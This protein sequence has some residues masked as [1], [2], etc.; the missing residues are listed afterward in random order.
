[1]SRRV[2][3]SLIAL[4]V[5]VGTV[6]PARA[7]QPDPLQ[8]VPLEPEGPASPGLIAYATPVEPP[9][10]SGA[11]VLAAGVLNVGTAQ[12]TAVGFEVSGPASTTITAVRDTASSSLDG[13]SGPTSWSCD[14]LRCRI[15]PA[16]VLE[17]GGSTT[18]L[19]GIDMPTGVRAEDLSIAPLSGD[20]AGF[21]AKVSA[22]ADDDRPHS[23]I[24]VDSGAPLEVTPGTDL[25]YEVLV[26]NLGD[27]AL[28][29]TKVTVADFVPPDAQT[30]SAT[31][32]GWE[33]ET[34]T[35]RCT[36]SGRFDPMAGPPPVSVTMTAA[37]DTGTDQAPTRVSIETADGRNLNGEANVEMRVSLPTTRGVHAQVRDGD[38][39]IEAGSTASVPVEIAS[40]DHRSSIVET[41][42]LAI[43]TPDGLVVDHQKLAGWD[44]E[45]EEAETICHHDGPIAGDTPL[46]APLTVRAHDDAKSGAGKITV[47]TWVGDSTRPSI[48]E[49]SSRVDVD[50]HTITV[51]PAG[52]AAPA[53]FVLRDTDDGFDVVHDGADLTF[54]VGE[55]TR[56]GI[57]VRNASNTVL[58]KGALATVELEVPTDLELQLSADSAWTCD[59][60][61]G[62]ESAGDSVDCTHESDA[63]LKPKAVLPVLAL[64]AI[65]RTEEKDVTWE[66]SAR[67][68]EGTPVDAAFESDSIVRS[69][70]L[71]PHIAVNESPRRGQTGHLGLSLTNQGEV[72]AN[73]GIALV[74]ANAQLSQPDAP[75]SDAWTCA[76]LGTG[77]LQLLGCSTDDAID[78]DASSSTLQLDIEV[79]EDDDTVAL[80]ARSASPGQVRNDASTA[81]LTTEVDEGLE[82]DAGRNQTISTPIRGPDGPIPAVVALT[83]RAT[84]DTN[85]DASWTQLCLD[86]ESVDQN[87]DLC[88]G[89]SPEVEW[90]EPD[91][92]TLSGS[93]PKTP[94]AKFRVPRSTGGPYT[95]AF[96]FSIGS[97]ESEAV[98]T[99]KV[100]VKPSIPDPGSGDDGSTTTSEDPTKPPPVIPVTPAQPGSGDNPTEPVYPAPTVRIIGPSA[101]QTRDHAT[102]SAS[103]SGTGDL[104]Y[105]WRWTGDKIPLTQ[106]ALDTKSVSFD[107]PSLS[108]TKSELNYGLEVTVTDASGATATD[109]ADFRVDWGSAKNASTEVSIGGPTFAVEGKPVTFHAK[110]WAF[111]APF[112]VSWSVQPQPAS[113]SKSRTGTGFTFTPPASGSYEVTAK[114]TDSFGRS[115]SAKTSIVATDGKITSPPKSFCDALSSATTSGSVSVGDHVA[116][117]W[118]TPQVTGACDNDWRTARIDFTS[119][120][121]TVYNTFSFT[122]SGILTFAGLELTGG[123]MDLGAAWGST[124]ARFAGGPGEQLWLPYTAVGPPPP[125]GPTP[126]AAFDLGALSGHVSADS[127]PFLTTPDGWN[128][129]GLSITFSANEAGTQRIAVSAAARADTGSG[130]IG[131]SG[132]LDTAGNYTV[133]MTSDDV[134]E[135]G[136][137]ALDATGTITGN[138]G[139]ATATIDAALDLH[140]PVAI[141]EHVQLSALDLTWRG[142]GSGGT[143]DPIF[144]GRSEVK[145]D[146]ADASTTIVGDLSFTSKRDWSIDL[147]SATRGWSP[148]EGLTFPA[149]SFTGS[150]SQTTGTGVK[151]DATAKVGSWKPIDQVQITDIAFSAT[152]ACQE[153][154][155][156]GCSTTL[157]FDA[158]IDFTVGDSVKTDLRGSLEP[159]TGIATLTAKI[160]QISLAG[161]VSISGG[162]LTLRDHPGADGLSVDL[163]GDSSM[164]GHT[165]TA[166]VAFSSEGWVVLA[167]LGRFTPIPGLEVPDV[168]LVYPSYSLTIDPDTWNPFGRPDLPG[169]PKLPSLGG[170]GSKKSDDNG[171]SI[172]VAAESLS[173]LS[174]MSLPAKI[175]QSGIV[176]ERV[177]SGWAQFDAGPSTS[178]VALH[179]P[180]PPDWFIVGSATKTTSLRLTEVGFEFTSSAA[181]IS[182]GIDGTAKLTL[183]TSRPGAA[184]STALDLDLDG[185]FATRA[186]GIDLTGSLSLVDSAGWQNAFGVS[187]LTLFDLEVQLGVGT[188]GPSLGFSASASLPPSWRQPI[189]IADGAVITAT[190]DLAVDSPCF[191]LDIHARDDK[192]A[193]DMGD[194]IVTA[195]S[196]SMSIAPAG[197]TVGETTVPAGFSFHFNGS[198]LG[199]PVR[200]DASMQVEP[201]RIDAKIEVGHF[202]AGAVTITGTT[203]TLEVEPN[204]FEVAIA[205]GFAI[206]GT[207]IAVTGSITA[208]A[209][210]TSLDLTGSLE[211]LKLAPGAELDEIDLS[212]HVTEG[213][214][215]TAALSMSAD[216][217]VLGNTEKIALSGTMANGLITKLDGT[218]D[219]DVPIGDVEMKGDLNFSYRRGQMPSLK[220]KV[221]LTVDGYL[222]SEASIEIDGNGIDVSGSV[223][224]PGVF[225]A[226]LEG[227]LV[228]G[229]D[230]GED[231]IKVRQQDGT[232]VDGQI[233][234]IWLEAKH[235]TV[236]LDGLTAQATIDFGS[237]S[238]KAYLDVDA[239]LHVGVGDSTTASI[240]GSVDSD[241]D[242]DLTG[243]L[244]VNLSGFDLDL[245]MHAAR[246]N[247]T[248]T[249]SGE[250]KLDVDPLL[251]TDIKGSFSGSDGTT[252]YTLSAKTNVDIEID[253]IEADVALS[254]APGKAGLRADFALTV[255]EDVTADV[256]MVASP[257]GA[258]S[259]S[260]AGKLAAGSDTID[261]TV[262]VANCGDKSCTSVGDTTISADGKVEA[263]GAEFSFS[264]S[265]SDDGD[266]SATLDTGT[267][268]KHGSLNL[269]VGEV[270]ASVE[271][272]LKVKISNE[273]IGSVSVKGSAS[274]SAR[275]ADGKWHSI[276]VSLSGSISSSGHVSLKV[277]GEIAGVHFKIKV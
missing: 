39:T 64:N 256:E 206:D 160:P 149:S 20:S 268:K 3:A 135:L 52:N 19:I 34:N 44:C 277:S 249:V 93:G 276:D 51:V 43:S 172:D 264:V 245:S 138:L 151:F 147:S 11:T 123:S 251:D 76:K 101:I 72:T 178:S 263:S 230:K 25:E 171:P 90:L 77:K 248:V 201:L 258:F 36:T 118:Q 158:S 97:D 102:F 125:A 176:P 63:A 239:T 67:F 106:G 40:A 105:E 99:V 190:A 8:P 126:S 174:P 121:V 78:V 53:L 41:T 162:S 255:G 68:G 238:D 124:E 26:T 33:C 114:V 115:N 6:A 128:P 198:I 65:A 271:F 259:A 200:V 109:R 13:V 94:S 103:G 58:Q 127:L 27:V 71:I 15:D 140:E 202:H 215:V 96:R 120:T 35:A 157:D 181:G 235:V 163:V 204:H 165:V 194:G 156:T 183:D 66:A 260:G 107:A 134:L 38:A 154:G 186:D 81:T 47:A 7:A 49:P 168:S 82:V 136:D 211:R 83:G 229:D 119:A 91:G 227:A 37:S 111:G 262:T 237:I 32:P 84:G 142:I 146:A 50:E 74:T 73:G 250:G 148:A 155:K 222:V 88:D 56:F 18:A 89:I 2:V 234:D 247:A 24:L 188:E 243:T 213:V 42:H 113:S 79:D 192:D 70:Q 80:A 104:T 224:V 131:L 252:T 31:G 191:A 108:A 9:E 184:G 92:K 208:D 233:G 273:G 145:I 223:E 98:D 217:E 267:S 129:H 1:M 212:V 187:G 210:G 228:W 139:A 209:T 110:P 167:D 17:E 231:K 16:T 10:G 253:T 275:V 266:F 274:A 254:N 133:D 161:G 199:T 85:A 132:T 270:K 150:L 86:P 28:E 5:A 205:G 226:Q 177:T 117:D 116:I 225:T 272:H 189:G 69:P 141:I 185:R 62:A 203:L 218:I 166:G 87:G 179:V 23:E 257:N 14:E 130:H 54:V 193:I 112:D 269:W 30:W 95:L 175:V 261:G 29:S 144:T 48:D 4:V 137:A 244:D 143:R 55:S 100:T 173:G 59:G 46:V 197:C 195:K 220:G 22:A 159:A 164:L 232:M 219:L 152:N 75:E 12:A 170:S 180:A 57:E 196:A 60:A 221:D 216:I 21:A 265:I 207:S 45:P 182:L 246:S 214:G 241:G 122:T 153:P 242:F 61:G 169:M 240:K 236:T